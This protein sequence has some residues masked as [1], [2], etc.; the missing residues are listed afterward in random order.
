MRLLSTTTYKFESFEDEDEFPN[1]A[2][3]SHTWVKDQEVS[4]QDMKRDHSLVENRSGYI[5]LMR[6]ARIAAN[7]GIQWIWV[8]TCC[9]DKTSSMELSEAINCS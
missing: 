4:F 1:Y 7:S 9:I 3:L 5:K 6:A 2:I 8:D